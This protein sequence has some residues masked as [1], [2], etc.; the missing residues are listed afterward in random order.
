MPMCSPRSESVLPRSLTLLQGWKLSPEAISPMHG[1]G[2]KPTPTIT[3]T[4]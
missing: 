3:S 4:P 1:P 2:Q